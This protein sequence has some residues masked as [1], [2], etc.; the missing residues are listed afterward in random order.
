MTEG[1]KVKTDE[2]LH[3][4]QEEV[5]LPSRGKFY[6]PVIPEGKLLLRPITTDEEKLFLASGSRMAVADRVLSACLLTANVAISDLLMTDK[7]Y[8]L[9]NLRALSYGPEYAFAIPCRGCGAKFNHTVVLPTG[10]NLKIATE[11]D[12]EPFDVELPVCKQT[13]SL[14]FLRGF[15]EEAVDDYVKQLSSGA[16]EQGDPGYAFRLSRHIVKIDGKEVDQL[17]KLAFV[18]TPLI[19]RDS[20]AIRRAIAERETGA[21]LTVEATCPSCRA[22]LSTLLPFSNEFFPSSVS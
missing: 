20:L 21:D 13:V 3:P 18:E 5:Q 15:D 10:L 14:R 6:D 17:A 4:Y 16:A 19:G 9:L 8:L 22:T 1:T 12:V 11:T 7:Y 2:K